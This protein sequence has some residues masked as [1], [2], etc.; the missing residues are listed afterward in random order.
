MIHLNTVAT[1]GKT[2]SAK[3]EEASKDGPQEVVAHLKFSGLF[4][5]R[6]IIAALCRQPA[7]WPDQ[8][9][10]D[11]LGAPRFKCSIALLDRKFSCTGTIRG[12]DENQSLTLLQANLTGIEVTLTELGG[13][14]AGALSW[15]AKGDEVE[16]VTELLGAVC[17]VEARLTDGEQQDLLKDAAR[18]FVDSVAES[19]GGSIQIGTGEKIDIPAKRKRGRRDGARA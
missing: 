15:T 6:D 10:Y 9:L 8:A 7:D 11:E 13:Q 12:P 19:G 3:R 1:L 14:V 18:K 5:T 16:D 4:V 17:K 2:F